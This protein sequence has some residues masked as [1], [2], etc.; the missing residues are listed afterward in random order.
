M[1]GYPDETGVSPLWGAF[2]AV[3]I[4]LRG[5]IDLGVA[6][7][8]SIGEVPAELPVRLLHVVER[9]AVPQF[10]FQP[11]LHVFNDCLVFGE[12]CLRGLDR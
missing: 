12:E 9:C 6:V 3:L 2:D 5:S 11:L 7:Q 8:Q 10:G 4:G 1:I